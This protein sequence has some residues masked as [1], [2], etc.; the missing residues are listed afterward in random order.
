MNA[1]LMQKYSVAADLLRDAAF[2]ARAQNTPWARACQECIDARDLVAGEDEKIAPLIEASSSD[3]EKAAREYQRDLV[4]WQID[5][6]ADIS[7]KRLVYISLVRDWNAE[8]AKCKANIL[9]WFQYYAW[10]LDPRPDAPLAIMPLV[11]FD[12]QQRYLLWLNDLVF[13][14][15][16][17]GLVEKSRDMGATYF[18][19]PGW[20]VYHWLFTP[21]F[22]VLAA[23]A[24]EDLVDSQKDPDTLFEKIRSQLRVQPVELMPKGFNLGRDMP[25]MN[26]A[27]PENGSV[28]TG[29]APTAKAGRQRRR[30]VALCDEFQTWPFGGFPQYTALSQTIKS[31]IMIGTPEGKFNKYS[32]IAHDNRTPRFE[33]DWREH[34]WKDERWYVSLP[35]GY[36]CPA[37]STEDIAQEVDRNFEA[38]QPGRVIKN[39]REEYCFI[40]WNEMVQGFG[41]QYRDRFYS[42]DGSKRLPSEWNWGRVADYGESARKEDDTHVWAYSLFAR[43][44]AAWPLNDSLFFF[45]SLP[46]M[47]IGATELQGFAFYSGLERELGLRNTQGWTKRPTVNDM[48]HEAKDPKEVLLKKCGDNWNLPDLDFDKGR[49][50]LIFHFEIVD[51]EIPNFFRPNLLGRCRIYFVSVDNEYFMAFNERTG[52]H[53]VTP[54]TTQRGFKRLRAEIGAWHYPPEE[55]G[56]PVPKMRPLSVFDD[57]ITTIR[58]GVARWGVDAAPLT[59]YQR[60][61]TKVHPNL[62]IKAIEQGVSDGSRDRQRAMMARMAEVAR[63]QQAERSANYVHPLA[64]M[65]TW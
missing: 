24:N 59:E 8:K 22:S 21:N 44:Q 36:L 13:T 45:Y 56:K 5:R 41:P 32:D 29:T 51:Q 26:I 14:R 1:E 61:E 10:G 7:R 25:Y 27:N 46:I 43:P 20:A 9:H 23:S 17:S 53:F 4:H 42:H 6:A 35:F 49:R 40:N 39:C 54:S 47:P 30:T 62:T 18:A 38:S 2:M 31:L 50:K 52:A 11:P 55:L 48:S 37:M 64:E 3:V 15:R 16:S 34:P 57:I 60:I 12:F 28:I 33:M 19:L 65:E 63:V 58:Y